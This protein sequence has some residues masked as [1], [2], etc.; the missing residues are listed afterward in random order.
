L[1]SAT[2]NFQCTWPLVGLFSLPAPGTVEAST[3]RLD[4]QALVRYYETGL[5]ALTLVEIRNNHDP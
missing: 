1:P 5:K 4:N 2:V 3:N